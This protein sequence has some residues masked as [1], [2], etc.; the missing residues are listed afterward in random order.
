MGNMMGDFIKGKSY[1]DFEIEI[2]EGIMLHRH[3]DTFTDAHPIISH[4]KAFFRK[5]YGLFSGILVDTLLD[6]FVANDNQIFNT[7]AELRKFVDHVYQT[8]L[9]H[10]NLM[11][12]RMNYLTTNM[13]QYD[14]LYN[15]RKIEG[16]ESSFKGMSKR[17]AMMPDAALACEIFRKNIN[18]LE[19]NY[20]L[21]I[22]DLKTE[23]YL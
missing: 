9:T 5:E 4:C 16:I 20:K 1:L 8:F 23:F 18:E 14:W 19:G 17:I 21:L 12:D 3:I 2:Q 11:S 10:K 7:E 15:Y 6:Y 13:I 22:T